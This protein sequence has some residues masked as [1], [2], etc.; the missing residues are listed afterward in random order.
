M[1]KKK[2]GDVE[3]LVHA[4]L[5]GGY[6]SFPD[7]EKDC[8]LP[9]DYPERFANKPAWQR[10]IVVSAGVIANVICAIALVMLVAIVSHKLPSGNYEIYAGEIS[11]PQNASIWD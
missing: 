4:F 11:A 6:V 3:I 9:K 8:D 2:V 7:D 5:L 10:A 1:F